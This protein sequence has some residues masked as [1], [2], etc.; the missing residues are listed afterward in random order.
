MSSRPWIRITLTIIIAALLLP[1]ANF[2]SAAASGSKEKLACNAIPR[3]D[4]SN[5]S[6]PTKID[7]K[8]L[9]MVPGTRLVLEGEANRGGGAK[10]HRV[11]FTV[12]DVTKMIN[13]VRTV[14]VWDR[15]I[16]DGEVVERELAFFA[17]DNDGNVWNLGEYPEEFEDG[18]FIGAESTWIAGVA[19][20][21]AGIH[22]WGTPKLD[23]PRYLQGYAPDIDFLDCAK[24]ID[25]GLEV[26]VPTGCYTHVLLTDE[27]SPLDPG[28]AHQRKFHAPGVGIVQVGAVN[29]PEGETLSL[30]KYEQLSPEELAAVRDDVL[31]AD[32]RAYEVAKDVYGGTPPAEYSP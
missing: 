20:A 21:K 1:L 10:P 8:W 27:T 9:P 16:E 29:D 6:N 7:N 13:G 30:V 2:R 28:N 31:D 14:V 32:K 12:S 4:P 26:C 18:E 5:F 3:F 22:M 24:V 17:Q 15:D 19:K 23:R 11:V 25:K